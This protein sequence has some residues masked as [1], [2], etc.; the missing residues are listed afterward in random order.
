M[1][2][3]EQAHKHKVKFQQHIVKNH[4]G[5]KYRRNLKSQNLEPESTTGLLGFLSIVEG[6]L[7]I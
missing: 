3:Y 6:Y 2:P 5:L 1:T 7:P 4:N